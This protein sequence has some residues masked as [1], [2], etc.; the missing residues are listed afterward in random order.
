MLDLGLD[1]E[2]IK[3]MYW[4]PCPDYEENKRQ[5]LQHSIAART[6]DWARV[7]FGVRQN[8]RKGVSGNLASGDIKAF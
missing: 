4:V 3:N 5:E 6:D 7:I 2:L 1:I 8:K